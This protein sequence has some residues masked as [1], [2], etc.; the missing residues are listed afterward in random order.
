MPFFAVH[1]TYADDPERV[2]EHRPAHRAFLQGLL[3][4]GTLLAAGAYTDGPAAALLLFRADSTAA[5]EELLSGDPFRHRGLV[6]ESRIRP[7]SAAIGP[8]AD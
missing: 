8:W 1:Y 6:T 7:W 5:V 2:A 3:D 4:Q